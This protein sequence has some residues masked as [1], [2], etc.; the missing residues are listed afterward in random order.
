MQKR[1]KWRVLEE[2]SR[3]EWEVGKKEHRKR[4]LSFLHGQDGGAPTGPGAQGEGTQLPPAAGEF[5]T[6]RADRH[7]KRHLGPK[8]TGMRSHGL[9]GPWWPHPGAFKRSKYN[10]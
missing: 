2:R 8:N 7:R 1:K 3:E 10:P 5:K 9:R 4:G 6:G